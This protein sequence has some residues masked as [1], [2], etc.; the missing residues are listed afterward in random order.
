MHHRSILLLAAVALVAPATIAQPVTLAFSSVAIRAARPEETAWNFKETEAGITITGAPVKALVSA[1]YDVKA[2]FVEGGPD[3]IGTT[4]YDIDAKL[5]AP[6]AQVLAKLTPLERAH[7]VRLMLRQ[8]LTQRFKL[9]T[10]ATT[11]ELTS[12]TLV[13]APGGVKIAQS[14]PLT[15]A[16]RGEPAAAKGPDGWTIYRESMDFWAAQLSTMAEIANPVINQTGLSGDY[17]F[18]FD[19]PVHDDPKATIFTELER[20]LGLKLEPHKTSVTILAVDHIERP[21]EN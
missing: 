2:Q 6:A 19:W 11:R 1:A 8:M 5:S 12:Y 10:T 13:A 3:W 4:V 14:P 17:K 15:P 7:Q 16:N 9:Q 20:Q 21:V 18:D